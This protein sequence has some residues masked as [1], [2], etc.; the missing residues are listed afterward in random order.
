MHDDAADSEYLPAVQPV[1]AAWPG[2][3]WYVPAAQIAHALWPVAPW[4]DHPAGQ[5]AHAAE[6]P[7]CAL[8]V[9]AAHA[10]HDVALE[11]PAPLCR[12][13]GQSAQALQPR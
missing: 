11:Q 8:Y 6:R 12:P 10:V 9:P 2:C 1:H 5:L 3:S 7:V 4:V 13:A